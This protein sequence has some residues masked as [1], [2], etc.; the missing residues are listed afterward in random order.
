[1]ML[2]PDTA[3]NDAPP[4]VAFPARHRYLVTFY[5]KCSSNY[6]DPCC[7]V[8][9]ATPEAARA[10]ALEVARRAGLRFEELVAERVSK[11]G[12]K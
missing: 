9:A 8:T 2:H 12:A 7:Y 3:R 4:R 6:G 10:M 11:W 5:G 1:M